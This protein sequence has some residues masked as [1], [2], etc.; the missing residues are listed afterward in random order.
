MNPI[1]AAQVTTLHNIQRITPLLAD[2][3][4]QAIAFF[5]D[6]RYY[7]A[8]VLNFFMIRWRMSAKALIRETREGLERV[9]DGDGE[10]K[11]A[12][13]E[14]LKKMCKIWLDNGGAN[15][16]SPDTLRCYCY[17]DLNRLTSRLDDRCREDD[18]PART[19]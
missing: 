4:D 15:G 7:R 6:E 10:L 19:A 12:E 14:M 9:I 11:A 17:R 8:L 5:T 13:R 16:Q 18:P 2:A 1:E 3:G